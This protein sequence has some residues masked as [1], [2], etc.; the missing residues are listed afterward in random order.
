MKDRI[1]QLCDV[2]RETGY[3]IHRYHGAGHLE[4]VYERA[5]FHRLQKLGLEAKCQH[6]LAVYD[7]D[8]TVLGE[9]F[10]D[11]VIENCLIVELKAA[12]AIA[13]EHVAQ[14]LGYLRASRIEHGL[15]INFGAGKFSIKKFVMSD[16]VP[17]KKSLI[18]LL[19]ASLCG[20]CG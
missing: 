1:F 16:T 9:Y 6:P 14:V 18:S 8:G 3:A 2:V 11:L 10:A 5:L 20:F 4:Q 13:D 7:E 19:F 17:S 12:R 15:L